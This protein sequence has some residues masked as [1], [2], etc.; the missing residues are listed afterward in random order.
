VKAVAG[1]S[2]RILVTM[3]L[4]G[5]SVMWAVDPATHISQYS[6]MVWRGQGG[7]FNGA[8]SA[9]T[10]TTDGYIWIGTESGLYR[11][12]GVRFVSWAE[13]T[14]QKQLQST[15]VSAL[16]GARDGSLWIGAGYRLYRWKGNKLSNY[17]TGDE[18]VSS[19][20]ETPQGTVWM[21]R[22]RQMPQVGALCQILDHGVHC[23]DGRGGVPLEVAFSLAADANGNL[24]IGGSSQLVRWHSGASRTWTLKTL[25]RSEGFEGIKALAVDKN[26]SLWVGSRY[27]EG[28]L[29]LKRFQDGVWKTYSSPG[30]DGAHT[31]V[32]KLFVDRDGALWVGTEDQG[33]YRIFDGKVDHF[34]GADGLSSDRIA[35]LFQDHEGTIWVV[36][37]KGIDSFH[38][39]PSIT[40]SKR[41]GLHADDAQSIL[42]SRSGTVW[43]GNVGALETWRHGNLTSILSGNGLPGREVTSLLEDDLG[44]LWVGVDDGLFRLEHRKFTKVQIPGVAGPLTAIIHGANDSIWAFNAKTGDVIHLQNGEFL[45]RHTPAPTEETLTIAADRSGNIWL[46]GDTLGYLHN[47]KTTM[48]SEFG[49]HYGYIR[50]I[51]IDDDGSI[52]FGA[53]KGLLQLINGKL[54]AMTIANGLP[55]GW[56]NALIFDNHRSLWI[57]SQCGLI[58]IERSELERWRQHPDAQVKST[59]FDTTDGFQGG[60]SSFRPAATKTP[61]GRLWFVNN[62][63]VQT[64]DPD[65]ISE[66]RLPPPVHIE[67][68]VADKTNYYPGDIHQL[69]KLT[70]Q[71]EIKYTGLSFMVPQRVRFRYKLAGYDKDWQ[72]ADTRRSAFYTNLRPGTYKFLVT[73]CNNSGIWNT[74]GATLTFVIPP[75]WYQTTWFH[76]LALLLLALLSYSLYLLRMRQYAAAIRARFDERLDERV[77]IARDLHDTL[78]QSFHSVL[79]KF[80]AAR[81]LLPRRQESAMQ[82]MD[83]AILATMQ[84]ITEGR[85][86]IYDL[87]PEPLAQPDLSELLRA[88]GQEWTQAQTSNMQI[89]N[90]RVVVEGRPRKLL[91]LLQE[92]IYRIGREVIRNAFSHAE[93][94][95]IEVEIRYDE[96]QLRLRIRDNGKGIDPKVL[97]ASGRP[98][99]WGLPGVSERAQ[100]I[101]SRL[102]FWSEAGAGTEVELVVPAAIA[103]EKPQHRR[104]FWLFSPGKDNGKRP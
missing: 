6:H 35:A 36:T 25:Q 77:R 15:E 73:A 32:S 50:T 28:E 90:L 22:E 55:C 88:V 60:A 80:Q 89:P 103:Y 34:S 71:L 40:I 21:T 18:F 98:G 47:N 42:A 104:R 2:I 31:A 97:D 70:H 75:A 102:E 72:E 79:F 13:L 54:Q 14:G 100:R 29:G 7:I 64:I 4:F 83:E 101:R 43:I 61:D 91:P 58:K 69:P 1:V 94:S 51:A 39:F 87:R 5:T 56:M 81:N 37:S 38:D 66:N 17:S 68:I 95:R 85:E 8:P 53:T 30:F 86:A 45:E 62:S 9:I 96:S 78:L 63:V 76:L 27:S 59:F 46:A 82:A 92:E 12:D 44:R 99:H 23:Y 41:E 16:L 3:I 20:I 49:P 33:L 65:H 19:I 48:V 26:N 67:Q 24:W 10:Q 93:A 52:L 57:S 74:E 84:A 11:F